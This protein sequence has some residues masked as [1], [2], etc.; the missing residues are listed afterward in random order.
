M[1]QIEIEL[2]EKITQFLFKGG[3][4]SEEDKKK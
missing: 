2:N 4:S 1:K 3:K